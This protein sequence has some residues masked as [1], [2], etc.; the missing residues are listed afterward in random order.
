MQDCVTSTQV[1]GNKVTVRRSEWL[2]SLGVCVYSAW[3]PTVRSLGGWRHAQVDYRSDPPLGRIGTLIPVCHEPFGPGRARALAR[4][5][6]LEW[7]RAYAAICHAF[8]G[9]A[10]RLDIRARAGEI[11]VLEHDSAKAGAPSDR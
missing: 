7:M 8:P 4:L 2:P 10:D 11:E 1:G 9:L 6:E 5:V 3:E